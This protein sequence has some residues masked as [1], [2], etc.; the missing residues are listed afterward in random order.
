MS[1]VLRKGFAFSL[2]LAFA[3]SASVVERIEVEGNNRVTKD[4]I[5]EASTL[6]IGD[7]LSPSKLSL[8]IK[9]VYSLSQFSDVAIR[10]ENGS[11]TISVEEV[12]LISTITFTG[13]REKKDKELR[14]KIGVEEGDP[15]FLPKI[16]ASKRALLSFY[17]EKGYHFAKVD[18]DVRDG[19]VIFLIEEGK[20]AKIKKIRL[21]GN[22]SFSSFRLRWKMET[23]KGDAYI[24]ERLESDIERI[25]QFYQEKGFAKVAID[26][27][28]VYYSEEKKGLIVDITIHEGSKYRIGRIRFWGNKLFSAPELKK[29][30][31][32]K[33][34]DLF[35]IKRLR[36]GF[37]EIGNLYYAK[38]Y[39][40]AQILPI[41]HFKL[42]EKV[43]D[44]EIRIA[45][46]EI[47]YIER[48]EITGNRKT[49][50]RVIYR[51][52]LIKPGELLCWDKVRKSRQKLALL[53]YFENVD[54]S[55]LSGSAPNKKIVRI[56]VVEGKR[57]TALFGISYTKQAGIV[58]SVDVNVVNLL[59]RGYSLNAK[60]EFGRKL[61]NYEI[62]FRDP[63]FMNTPTSL[64]LGLWH[65]ELKR[66]YYK[67][68]KR[69]GYISLSR[70]ISLFNRVRAKY[71]LDQS[72]F[73]DVEEG[74]PEDV[75]DW[76]EE[77]G[78]RYAV[79]SS[80]ELGFIRDTRAPTIFD[81]ETGC[82]LSISC[83][84][85]GGVLGGD[86]E[87]Y[88]PI[89]EGAWYIP[90]FWK[91]ILVFHTNFGFVE[92]ISEKKVPDYEKFYLGGARTVRGYAER[93]ICLREGGGDSFFYINSEYRL[94]LGK[95]LSL[96][97]FLDAGQVWRKGEEEL[98]DL[99]SGAG[100]GMR[101]N[102]PIGPMRF[103]YAWPL[104][105]EREPRF[106]FSIGPSF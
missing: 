13:N 50:D 69:G 10:Q 92:P 25:V 7:E 55:I 24:P 39:I 21:F 66:D 74:A 2:L 58:G 77:W 67:E 52:L 12:P 96:T 38:G 35:N 61:V 85:A 101:F 16:E 64:G 100:F 59:G 51:E 78:E 75:R 14:G 1:S 27:P 49:K 17:K 4:E 30:I 40:S 95:G 76:R 82:R 36:E 91:F 81:P 43:V 90:S 20:E 83:E 79:T 94:P 8:A 56:E 103:D 42:R 71:R 99:I 32:I 98:L 106:H 86:I 9:G 62:G 41:P 57:G 88:K 48:I 26:P 54:I 3:S 47:A 37:R 72:K 23:G 34:G 97:A 80:L 73:T 22:D 63:W 31:K 15:T 102:S 33:E 84:T 93:S 89:F 68:A 45:E 70:P 87:F 28:K 29:V 105:G 104:N 46:G 60:C 19:E 6:K 44:Y 65:K 18:V 53:G 5:V 11:L